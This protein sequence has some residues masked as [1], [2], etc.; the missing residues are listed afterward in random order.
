MANK[1]TEQWID[2]Y[3]SKEDTKENIPNTFVIE[4]KG[5]VIERICTTTTNFDKKIFVKQIEPNK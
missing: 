2:G 3:P 4:E 1:G 5:I